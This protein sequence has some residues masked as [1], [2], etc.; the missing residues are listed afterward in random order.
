MKDLISYLIVGLGIAGFVGGLIVAVLFAPKL[1]ID[2]RQ[3]LKR[4]F[5]SSLFAVSGIFLLFLSMGAG[6][7]LGLRG[8][9]F[10]DSILVMLEY[11]LLGT[12]IFTLLNYA[13]IMILEKHAETMEHFIKHLNNRRK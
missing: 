2:K 6:D 5:L 9:A 3:W 11:F 7:S 8:K 1:S 10:W 12:I 4:S 13:R